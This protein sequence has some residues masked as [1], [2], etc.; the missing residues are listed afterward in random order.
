MSKFPENHQKFAYL[1]SLNLPLGRYAITG[2]GP[3]G[4]RDVRAVGDI[5]LIVDDILWGKLAFYH[6]VDTSVAFNRINIGPYIEVLG[7]GSILAPRITSPTLS[8]MLAAAEIIAELPFITLPHLLHFKEQ[9][10][11]RPKDQPDI[12]ALKRLLRPLATL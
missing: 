9:I 4:I 2:S 5:D 11:N 6:P 1:R 7:E 3:L 10:L 8:E 12:A